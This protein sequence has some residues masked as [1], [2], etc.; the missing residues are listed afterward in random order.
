MNVP[1]PAPP[2]DPMVD[3][4]NKINDAHEQV[5]LTLKSTGQAAIKVGLLLLD[6]KRLSGHGSF[7][8]W[9]CANCNFSERTAQLYMQM[10]KQFPNPQ[11]FADF[12]LS[13]LMKMMGPLK[14]QEPKEKSA[15][16]GPRDKVAEAIAK[17]PLAVLQK[18]WDAAA[19]NERKLF[20]TRV[21]P[22]T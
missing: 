6:A 7:A 13:D 19:D 2:N 8:D 11:N 14:L 3:L 1:T 9:I 18:A 17:G 10:A 20:L 12:S 4:I 5:R 16:S 22:T 15:R 21:R